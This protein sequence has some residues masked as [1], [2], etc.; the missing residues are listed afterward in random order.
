M[1]YT[2]PKEREETRAQT[3][4]TIPDR[5]R[6][7]FDDLKKRIRDYEHATLE[8]GSPERVW[9]PSA[10]TIWALALAV[11]VVMVVAF[12][13]GYIPLK[14]QQTQVFTEALQQ[15][16]SLP[17]V[18]AIQ[19][20]RGAGEKGLELPG[21]IQAVTEAPVLARADGYIR[22]RMVDIGDR[23]AAGQVLADI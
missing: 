9:K 8:G 18:E 2:D 20:R 23:G 15:E 12:F 22:R 21:T 3:D 6:R 4:E 7:E 14:K 1:R 13:A 17:R 16:Q 19:A 5:L 11:V 10:I